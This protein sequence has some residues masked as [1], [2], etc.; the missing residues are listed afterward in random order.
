MG[1]QR[2]CGVRPVC[3]A[4]RASAG[5]SAAA[6]FDRRMEVRKLVAAHRKQQREHEQGRENE[7]AS[8]RADKGH[9]CSDGSHRAI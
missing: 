9:G 4:T 5:Y 2:S 8:D 3:F 7:P 6:L 1:R